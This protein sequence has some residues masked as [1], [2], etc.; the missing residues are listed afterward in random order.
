MLS[1]LWCFAIHYVKALTFREG[2]LAQA[3]NLQN[4]WKTILL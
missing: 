1:I 3:G 4:T 2:G